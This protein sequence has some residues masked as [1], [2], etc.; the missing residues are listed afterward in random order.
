HNQ[1]DDSPVSSLSSSH[2][3]WFHRHAPA[4]TWHL[5]DV[6][7]QSL[8]G[9]QG[10]VAASLFDGDGRLAASLLQGVF[11]RH[12]SAS[13]RDPLGDH[14]GD[15]DGAEVEEKAW[16]VQPAA[17]AAPGPSPRSSCWPP[18]LCGGRLGGTTTM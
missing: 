5:F 9:N 4:H 10:F 11:V 16:L 1:L 12:T 17:G 8:A 15:V 7:T 2:A 13:Q 14:G 6:H 3:V 18:P